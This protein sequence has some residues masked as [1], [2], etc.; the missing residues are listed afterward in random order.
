[1]SSGDDTEPPAIHWLTACAPPEP[2]R[3]THILHR[4]THYEAAGPEILSQSPTD[5]YELVFRVQAVEVVRQLSMR[6]NG[7]SAGAGRV[8]VI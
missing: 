7:A 2:H 1:M 6:S 8:A 4:V 5:C 3:G